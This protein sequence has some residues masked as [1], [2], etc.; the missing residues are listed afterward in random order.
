MRLQRL[1]SWALGLSV[2]VGLVVVPALPA[3]ADAVSC[4]VTGA[5]AW[6]APGGTAVR[7]LPYVSGASLSC[8]GLTG[9]NISEV[10][11]VFTNGGH[12]GYVFWSPNGGASDGAW[13]GGSV[14]VLYGSV[15]DADTPDLALFG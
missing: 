8:T 10:D 6:A 11:V 15:A 12:M 13:P 7:T 14:P 9:S 1:V 4:V 5:P 2:G 3:S